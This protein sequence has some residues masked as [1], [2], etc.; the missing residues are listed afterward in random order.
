MSVVDRMVNIVS[1]AFVAFAA[2]LLVLG[3]AAPAYTTPRDGL[4]ESGMTYQLGIWTAILLLSIGIY[5]FYALG[6]MDYSGDTI[7]FVETE[8]H[9]HEE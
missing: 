9:Q 1:S 2:S 4:T 6:S 3:D 7:L 5:A 8:S